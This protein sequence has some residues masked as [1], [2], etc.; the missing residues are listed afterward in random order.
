MKY[1]MNFM[2]DIFNVVVR[3]VSDIKLNFYG[4]IIR[5]IVTIRFIIKNITKHNIHERKGYTNKTSVKKE[6][7]G[8]ARKTKEFKN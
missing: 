1:S 2:Q 3:S 4:K 8:Y 7:E 5:S 6:N